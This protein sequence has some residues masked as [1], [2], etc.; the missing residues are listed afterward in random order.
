VQ[1]NVTARHVEVSEAL[2]EY[3]D[4][5]LGRLTKYYDRIQ[6]I[7]A[8]VEE[9]G[10]LRYQLSVEINAEHK[11]F[12]N[13]RESGDDLYAMTDLVADKL[14]TQLTRHKEKFRNRKHPQ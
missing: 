9:E 4:R 14:A 3:L 5:K 1:I 11:K 7:E 13:A 12:F 8:T 2:R 10:D 6:A